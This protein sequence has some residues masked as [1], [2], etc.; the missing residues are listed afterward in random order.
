MLPLRAII[1]ALRPTR[2]RC[3]S[4]ATR[5]RFERVWDVV[6]TLIFA[7]CL[8]ST[9]VVFRLTGSGLAA[10]ERWV[11]VAVLAVSLIFSEWWAAR[12]LRKRKLQKV[13]RGGHPE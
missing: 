2:L 7:I 12:I 4:C 3:P 13:S 6:G 8:M 9:L 5:L 10:G 1:L 11:W